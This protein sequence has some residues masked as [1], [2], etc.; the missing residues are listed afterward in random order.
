MYW[1]LP[2]K[3]RRWHAAWLSEKEAS[4]EDPVAERQWHY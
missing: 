4:V 2:A 1:R 3:D